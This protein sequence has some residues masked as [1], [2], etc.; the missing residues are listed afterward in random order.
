[1]IVYYIVVV[2]ISPNIFIGKQAKKAIKNIFCV[3][4]PYGN[5][6]RLKTY[7]IILKKKIVYIFRYKISRKIK[8]KNCTKIQT[9]CCCGEDYRIWEALRLI[10]RV[11]NAQYCM[12]TST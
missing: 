4:L 6:M 10:T 2:N 12:T 1:M 5:C 3:L 8:A 11:F 9:M 7:I